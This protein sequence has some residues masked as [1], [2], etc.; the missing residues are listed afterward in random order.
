MVKLIM[1]LYGLV[2]VGTDGDDHHENPNPKNRYTS[3]SS[4]TRDPKP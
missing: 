1:R 2:I 4:N 3:L